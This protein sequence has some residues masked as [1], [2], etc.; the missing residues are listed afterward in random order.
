MATTKADVMEWV[1][2]QLAQDTKFREAV[3]TRLTE[4]RL[5]QQL[6]QLRQARGLSQQQVARIAGVSQPAVAK[7]ESGA[8]KNVELKTLVKMVTA[9]GGTL[10]VEILPPTRVVGIQRR[11]ELAAAARRRAIGYGRGP[12]P[13]TD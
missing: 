13:R 4:L 6:A 3:E 11:R 7:L 12:R 9:L 2:Q 10:K 1:E 8:M 5:E